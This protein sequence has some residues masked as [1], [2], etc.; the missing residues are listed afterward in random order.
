MGASRWISQRV[1]TSPSSSLV[2]SSGQQVNRV[3]KSYT[4]MLKMMKNLKGKGIMS[5]G[6]R[7]KLPKGLNR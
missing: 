6:K 3:L 5:G 7:R 1:A 4:M 2:M